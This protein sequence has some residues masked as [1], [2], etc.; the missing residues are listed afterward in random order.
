MS[1]RPRKRSD[2]EV[3]LRLPL[4]ASERRNPYTRRSR[5]PWTPELEQR[6][7][8]RLAMKARRPKHAH[9]LA[10]RAYLPPPGFLAASLLGAT[11][12]R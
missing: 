2:L 9:P 10:Y 1:F 6:Y 7:R 12:I 8:T 11:V 4:P 5:E 3:A